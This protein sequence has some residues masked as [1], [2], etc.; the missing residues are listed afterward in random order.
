[1]AAGIPVVSLHNLE[2][3]KNWKNLT[4][5]SCFVSQLCKNEQDRFN[6]HKIHCRPRESTKNIR[7]ISPEIKW[8]PSCWF[9]D[10]RKKESDWLGSN[11][12]PDW[13]REV[14][15]DGWL[16]AG[17]CATL[18]DYSLRDSQPLCTQP[19]LGSKDIQQ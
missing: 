10:I 9:P 11:L 19:C 1:M 7:F 16:L 5:F 12:L 14:T 17:L 8:C 4:K 6:I 18:Q 3:P 13:R 2:T 15:W